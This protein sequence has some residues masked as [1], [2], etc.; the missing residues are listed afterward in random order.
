VYVAGALLDLPL[1]RTAE[2]N[3]YRE[4]LIQVNQAIRAVQ[5][6]EDAVKLQV[7]NDLRDL[8]QTRESFR[9][10]AQA[11][12]LAQRRVKSTQLFQ[13]AGRAQMRDVLEAQQAL[14]DAQ[15]A[16]SAALVNYRV[17]ELGLQRDMGLLQVDQK[18]IWSEYRPPTRP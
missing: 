16:L 15:N 1:E 6:L 8:I 3:A 2:R 4:A 12:A 14:L 5:E 9:I 18:G 13:E 17:A 10:Q 11:V 7:R